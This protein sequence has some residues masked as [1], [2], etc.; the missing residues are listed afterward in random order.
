MNHLF[1]I[2]ATLEQLPPNSEAV[3]ATVVS[4]EGSAYRQPGAR[5][6]I[7]ADGQSVGMVSGGCLE[8]HL[9]Q[10]AF[11]S[12]DMGQRSKPIIPQPIASCHKMR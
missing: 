11:G 9:V 4:V 2:F 10:R 8:K 1:D 7:L 3:L 12:L 5:M 6:L